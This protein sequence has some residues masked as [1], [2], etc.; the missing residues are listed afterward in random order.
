M[1]ILQAVLFAHLVAG[2]ISGVYYFLIEVDFLP[3][4]CTYLT[5]LT[6]EQSLEILKTLGVWALVTLFGLEL[7]FVAYLYYGCLFGRGAV[8]VLGK[9]LRALYRRWVGN[10]QR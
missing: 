10:G 5:D 8:A 1:E 2:L 9:G 3:V 4:N 7:F 6:D